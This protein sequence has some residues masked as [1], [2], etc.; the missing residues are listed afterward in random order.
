[1]ALLKTIWRKQYF[2]KVA[3][4]APFE[5]GIEFKFSTFT[6]CWTAWKVSNFFIPSWL[7]FLLFILLKHFKTNLLKFIPS[8]ILWLAC[9]FEIFWS[10]ILVLWIVSR[11][12]DQM[13]FQK[14]RRKK[15]R[16][17][18]RR[19]QNLEVDQEIRFKH[20]IATSSSNYFN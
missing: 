2:L 6:K 18:D 17:R 7:F 16:G 15:E 12:E 1:M 5:T 14:Y 10:K 13:T 8:T 3:Q 19:V 4:P 9:H 20:Y 11:V